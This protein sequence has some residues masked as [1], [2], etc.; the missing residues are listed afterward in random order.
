[1]REQQRDT[2]Q[3]VLVRSAERLAGVLRVPGDKS[4]SHRVAMLA[5]LSSGEVAVHGFLRSEDCLNTLR[6]AVALGARAETEREPVVIS[7]TGGRFRAPAGVLDLGNSGTGM[8]LLSGLLAGQEF[9]CELTGD[10]SLRSRPMQRIREPLERMGAQVALLGEGGCA[11][12]RIAGGALHGIEYPLPVASAQVKSCTLLAGL[13]AEGRTVVIEPKPTRDHTE[14]LL[15]ALGVPL[16]IDGLRIELDGYGPD[17]PDWAARDW[18]VPGDFSSAAFWLTAAAAR[19]GS[20]LTVERVGLNPR[21]TA[22]LDVLR[23]MG[24][25]LEVRREPESETVEPAGA[26]RMRGGALRATEIGGA[27]IPN[28]IDEIPLVAVAG[29]LA[30]GRTVIRDAAE[31]RVKESDRIASMASNLA[32]LG[33]RLEERADGMVIEGPAKLTGGVVESFGDH[34]IA[35]ALTVLACFCPAPVEVRD[36][37]CVATSYPGFWSDAGKIGVKIDRCRSD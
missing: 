15:L 10:A 7:G 19:P 11:P 13:F 37:G 16:R 33:V 3:D 35:M 23:R 22:L 9:A 4:I 5:A 32:R 31:L 25:Q 20:D 6:A 14:R 27:E 1:M 12:L 18:R 21:R 30:E 2:P 28:L 36:V 8:R 26:V 34:R 24:A 29:A 17:G